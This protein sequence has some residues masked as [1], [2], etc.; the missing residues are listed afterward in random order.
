MV[1][2]QSCHGLPK[3]LGPTVRCETCENAKSTKT[4]SLGSTLRT[5]DKPLQL[6]VANLCGPFQERSIGGAAYLLQVRDVYLNYVKVYTIIHKYDVT[7]L[8]KRYIAESERL[9]GFKVVIWRNDGG[10]EFLNT[11]MQSHLQELGLT[12]EKTILYFHEQAGVVE[13]FNR[14]I[15]SIMRCIPLGSDLPRTF[16]GMVVASAAYLHNRTI[17][18]NTKAKAP[19]EL[20]L[21]VH[22][23]VNNLRIFGSCAFVHVPAERSK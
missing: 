19:Q 1:S 3:K 8:V 22:A 14:M 4:L 2:K 13:R 10:G 15:Q 9:T 17:N 18:T 7:G 16:W 6:V 11:E 12:L 20:F 23:Q 21:G 5:V